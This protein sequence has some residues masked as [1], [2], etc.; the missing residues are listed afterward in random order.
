MRR[1]VRDAL[2]DELELPIMPELCLAVRRK[3]LDP[4]SSASDLTLIIQTD[5]AISTKLVQVAQLHLLASVP[6]AQVPELEKAPAV[7][8]LGLTLDDAGKGIAVLIAARHDIERV[9]AA[10]AI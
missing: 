4:N 3:T 8:N 5:I 2:N 7:T 1:I 10:L 6:G 9:R